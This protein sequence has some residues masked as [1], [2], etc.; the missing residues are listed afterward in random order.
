MTT[1]INLYVCENYAPEFKSICEEKGWTEVGVIPFPS[2]CVNKRKKEDVS[3]LLS[4]NSMISNENV[5]LCSKYCD[6]LTLIPPGTD[7]EVHSANYCFTHLASDPFINYVLAKDGYIIGSGWLKDWRDR[8]AEAGFDQETAINFYHDFCKELVFFDAGI[9]KDA[10][11]DLEELSQFLKLPYIVVPVELECMRMLI[12]KVVSQ[13]RLHTK[14]TD[15]SREIAEIQTQCAEYAAIFDL[16]GRIADYTN[17]RNVIEKVKEIFLIVFGAQQFKYWNNEYEKDSLPTDIKSLFLNEEQ[18]YIFSKEQN[19]FCIKIKWHDIL[20]GA[21]D[22]S[23]F[24]FPGYIE[25]YLNFAIEIAKICG[26]VFSNSEQYEK[27][28]KSEQE[29][30]YSGTHDALTKLYNRTYINEIIESQAPTHP[31][32]VFMFDIDRLKYVNDHFG[33]AEGDK[34]IIAV[35]AVL[36][37]CLREN[38]ILARIGGDEFVAILPETNAEAAEIIKDRILQQIEIYNTKKQEEHLMISFSIGYAVGET[39]ED[40]TEKLMRKADDMMYIDKQSKSLL[41]K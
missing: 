6:I 30:R 31:F 34:L 37:K 8:I 2:M 16:M 7:I 14:N 36:K 9:Y 11:K 26:L 33:H 18:A 29:L 40:E 5:V 13:R 24:L 25:K 4:E 1:K 3:K 32:T 19:R 10:K 21:V 35:S 28:L 27:I 22:V 23:G 17:K 12:D 39:P 15:N 38:D 20:Y 41:N